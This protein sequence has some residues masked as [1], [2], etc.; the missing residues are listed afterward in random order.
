[1]EP[2]NPPAGQQ[3]ETEQPSGPVRSLAGD[4][5]QT[6][7]LPAFPQWLHG[8]TQRA[9]Q[10]SIS[11]KAIFSCPLLHKTLGQEIKYSNPTQEDMTCFC[12]Y[13]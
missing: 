13:V 8:H 1:M 11:K 5:A 9:N 12:L 3:T 2:L 7:R 10:C 6:S 4:T